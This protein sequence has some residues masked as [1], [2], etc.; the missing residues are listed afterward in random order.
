MNLNLTKKLR[1]Q[2]TEKKITVCVFLIANLPYKFNNQ[3]KQQ[4][5]PK[6]DGD[7]L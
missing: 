2:M 4:I 6:L 5:D 7:I 1:S 3:T